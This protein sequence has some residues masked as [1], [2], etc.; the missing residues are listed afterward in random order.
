MTG[1]VNCQVSFATPLWIRNSV[2]VLYLRGENALLWTVNCSWLS[3]LPVPDGRCRLGTA[4]GLNLICLGGTGCPS[5]SYFKFLSNTDGWKCLQQILWL[6]GLNA[7]FL[8]HSL[9]HLFL[10]S[11]SLG[12]VKNVSCDRPLPWRLPQPNTEQLGIVKG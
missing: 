3:S 1:Y 4:P 6:V 7:S 2:P 10:V 9:I 12:K 8:P 5:N 11:L